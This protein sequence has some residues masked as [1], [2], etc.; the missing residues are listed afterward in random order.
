M[1][2]APIQLA[3]N[4]LFAG[5]LNSLKR[6]PIEEEEARG[7]AHFNGC[8]RTSA[9]KRAS[10]AGRLGRPSKRGQRRKRKRKK[11]ER[12]LPWSR[13][14]LLGNQTERTIRLSR[15]TKANSSPSKPLARSAGCLL[16]FCSRPTHCHS[17][18]TN[19]RTNEGRRQCKLRAHHADWRSPRAASAR[20][21]NGVKTSRQKAPRRRRQR[22]QAIK[23]CAPMG[24]SR[25]RACVKRRPASD[26]LAPSA[27]S[28]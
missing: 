19:E 20:E 13:W 4:Y 14:L 22:G 25:A 8:A 10:A 23:E 16:A 6:A 18:R 15:P 11:E 7:W 27:H 2:S 21:V 24:D 5:N 17:R 1:S 28:G 26:Q 9:A 3:G 12:V